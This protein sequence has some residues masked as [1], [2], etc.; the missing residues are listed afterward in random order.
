MNDLL[1]T[2]VFFNGK[3][4]DIAI[5]NGK[6]ISIS[7]AGDSREDANEIFAADKKLAAFP[8]FYNT[9]THAAMSLLRGYAEDLELFEW[10]NEHI[11]PAE[12][13]LTEEDVYVGTR[14]A[15]IE[16]I[17]SGTVYFNDSYWMPEA[18]LRAVRESGMRATLGLLYLCDTNGNIAPKAVA[19]NEK[20]LDAAKSSTYRKINISHSPHA[21]YTVPEKVLR[22][23]SQQM[24]KDALPLHI[25]VAETEKEFNDCRNQHNGMTPVEYLDS[26]GLIRNNAMLAHCVYL[27]DNDRKIIAE[28]GAYIAH[29]PVSNMKLCSGLFEYEK[30]KAAGCKIT[31]GT[32]GCSSNNSLSM[33]DE[34]KFAAL[35]AKTS[36]KQPTAG[37]VDSIFNAATIG[38]MPFA[39][40]A[41]DAADLMLIDLEH[42]VLRSAHDIKSTL[43]YAG[44]PGMVDT[45]ICGGEILMKN[46]HIPGEKEIVDAAYD[47]CK[48]IGNFK[49]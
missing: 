3:L 16:M 13:K 11:W 32:D 46:K 35:T 19:D 30:A 29:N 1:I 15:T 20:L 37:N 40:V 25:H 6:I 4:S 47:I 34:M 38:G 31:I 43:V 36:A 27:T 49:K 48:K 17:R 14:L 23:I 22:S 41:E 18:A 26:L 33:F 9:H 21:I 45:L 44:E 7:D 5:A 24:D 12:A 10:L 39:G 42:P 8:P 2:D 28:R